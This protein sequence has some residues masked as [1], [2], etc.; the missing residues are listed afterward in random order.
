MEQDSLSG[1][2]TMDFQPMSL[3]TVNPVMEMEMEIPSLWSETSQEQEQPKE[4][5]E[6]TSEETDDSIDE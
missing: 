2:P 4:Q 6:E 1:I 3:D 5:E